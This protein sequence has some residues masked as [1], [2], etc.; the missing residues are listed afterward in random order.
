MRK[1]K[2]FGEKFQRIL[3]H[4]DWSAKPGASRLSDQGISDYR[5]SWGYEDGR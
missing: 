1:V 5:Q 3:K 2:R 4:G